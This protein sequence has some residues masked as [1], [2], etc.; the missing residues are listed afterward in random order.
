MTLKF[1]NFTLQIS[2]KRTVVPMSYAPSVLTN[3][4]QIRNVSADFSEKLRNIK[5]PM[6]IR[7]RRGKTGKR[8]D[9]TKLTGFFFRNYAFPRPTNISSMTNFMKIPPSGSPVCYTRTN[10]RTNMHGEFLQLV[11]ANA[12]QYFAA[13]VLQCPVVP[14][15]EEA[16]RVD[17][18][19]LTSVTRLHSV[20]ASEEGSNRRLEKTA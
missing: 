4:N 6:E 16:C 18:Q 11:L 2:I 13:R 17:G 3:F 12:S 20:W 15:Q 1:Y 10:G 19:H 9:M 7:D 5:I 14:V 8:T